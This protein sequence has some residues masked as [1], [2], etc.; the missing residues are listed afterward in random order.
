LEAYA[1][2]KAIVILRRPA[3]V[4]RFLAALGQRDDPAALTPF[5]FRP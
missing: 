1:D 4:Q 2:Q 3:D 5:L